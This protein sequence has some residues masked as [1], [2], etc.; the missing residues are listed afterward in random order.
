MH[1][2]S[3]YVAEWQESIFQHLRVFTHHQMSDTA[4]LLAVKMVPQDAQGC[5]L[6]HTPAHMMVS[7]KIPR[8]V[9]C[10]WTGWGG[11]RGTDCHN[12]AGTKP[13]CTSL[14]DVSSTK[15]EPHSL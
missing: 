5:V 8:T 6:G 14:T 15:Q 3:P 9:K 13:S 11:T 1:R 12:Q 10:A 7:R 2:H 4:K